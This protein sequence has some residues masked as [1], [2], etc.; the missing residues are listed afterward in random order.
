ML[1]SATRAFLLAAVL[2]AASVAAAQVAP[3]APASAIPPAH[4]IVATHGMVVAQESRAA[5]I[6]IAILDRGRRSCW[7][8]CVA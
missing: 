7:R 8:G 6:G 4:A 2:T 1:K 5:R 3:V